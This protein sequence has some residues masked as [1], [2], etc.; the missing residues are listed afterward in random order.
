MLGGASRP[1]RWVMVETPC[2]PHSPWGVLSTVC[3]PSPLNVSSVP[4]RG[5]NVTTQPRLSPGPQGAVWRGNLKYLG[6]SL[7]LPAAAAIY[8]LTKKR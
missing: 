7:G 8:H 6:I 3:S 5:R 2:P 1:R 4:V